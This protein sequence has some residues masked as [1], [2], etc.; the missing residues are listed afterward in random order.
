MK[1]ILGIGNALTDVFVDL[2]NDSLLRHFGLV[3]GIPCHID[4]DLNSELQKI[5]FSDSFHRTATMVAGGSAAG[6]IITA[7]KLGMKAS[8]FGKIG[9]DHIGEFYAD[10][11]TCSNVNATL[12][13][14]KLPTGTSMVFN[15]TDALKFAI[16]TYRG[17]SIEL[18]PEDITP[19]I[20][21]G[22][23]YLHTESFL[24]HNRVLFSRIFSMA[25]NAGCIISLDLSAPIMMTMNREFVLQVLHDYVDIVFTTEEE[26]FALTGRSTPKRVLE[27]LSELCGIVALKSGENG[28]I[29]KSHD[30]CHVIPPVPIANPPHDT[31]GAGDAYAAGFLYAHSLG[32]SLRKC[33]ESASYYASHHIDKSRIRC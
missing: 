25:S 19:D 6:T 27:D 14:G 23:D 29:V 9:E 13:K 3:F 28:S 22:Q 31:V 32:Q 20:F 21:A 15:V 17:A 7:S 16:A 8:F 33:G 2:E 10:Q 11:M 12:L 30:E 18:K 5:I 1:S 24:L 26:A 4:K